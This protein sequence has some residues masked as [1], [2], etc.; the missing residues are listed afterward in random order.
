MPVHPFGTFTGALWWVAP[1][2]TPSV[3]QLDTPWL[4][5]GVKAAC[6]QASTLTW[7][8]LLSLHLTL[9][10]LPNKFHFQLLLWMGVSVLRAHLGESWV[11]APTEGNLGGWSGPKSMLDAGGTRRETRGFRGSYWADWRAKARS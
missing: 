1:S 3:G 11:P 9:L 7:P 2:S 10:H 8:H 4:R 5:V 6:R